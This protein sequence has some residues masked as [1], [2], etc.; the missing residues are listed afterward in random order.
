[1]NK[2]LRILYT[3]FILLFFSAE[4]FTCTT[5]VISGKFTMN[6]KP[7]LF[8]NRDSKEMQNSLAFFTDS[9]YKYIGLVNGTDEWYKMVWGGYNETGNYDFTKYDA[10]DPSVAPDGILIRTNHSL[11]ADLTKGF[12][13]CRFNTATAILSQVTA[14]NKISPQFLFNNIS[15]NLTHSLTKTDLWND[16]PEARNIPE[17]RFF[18]DYIPR[19]STASAIM[20]VGAEDKEHVKNAMMW[21]ILGFPLASVAVPT[22][23]VG[24]NNLPKA[25]SLD[26]NKHSPLCNAALKLKEECFPITYDK[27]WNY[28]NLS[29][30]INQQ[31]NGIMQ[32]LQP[33]ENVIFDKA[34]LFMTE[35]E[36]SKNPEQDIQN[37]YD[38]IDQY[39]L[40]TFKVQ[41]DIKL[42]ED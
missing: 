10:N 2:N 3:A 35:L 27:G 31:N 9:K 38:W 26:E 17:F 20:I 30:V 14:K 40:K 33:I 32:L 12:G 16:L 36:K 13:F 4:A 39:L 23:I 7:I 42:F 25:V 24:G 6:G 22:W 8:K 21:T 28:I 18:I 34:H 1:M 5:F 19:L 37:F 15:R 11:R 29:A 41:F